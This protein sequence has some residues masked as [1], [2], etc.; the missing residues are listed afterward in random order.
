MTDSVRR[1]RK[2]YTFFVIFLKTQL[3]KIALI[4]LCQ[5]K[6]NS[7]P[8]YSACLN[9]FSKLAVLLATDPSVGRLLKSIKSGLCL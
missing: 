9:A 2:N 6:I 8:K 1:N 7:I 5:Q 3:S 4:A